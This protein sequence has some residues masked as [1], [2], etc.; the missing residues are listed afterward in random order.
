MGLR[1]IRRHASIRPA[2]AALAYDELLGLELFLLRT[3]DAHDLYA[4]FG[5]TTVSNPS[6]LMAKS[7]R[8]D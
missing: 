8:A 1:A 3:R 5:F 4:Q 2:Q 6:E 7:R